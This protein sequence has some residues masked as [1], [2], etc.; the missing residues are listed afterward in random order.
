MKTALR[1]SAVKYL[2]TQPYI[3]GMEAELDRRWWKLELDTPSDCARKLADGQVDI[4]L[5]PV[6]AIPHL[7][8]YRPITNWGI[9]ADGAVKSV[10]LL[11]QVPIEEVKAVYFDYQSKTSNALLSILMKEFFH[12]EVMILESQEGYEE[13]IKSDVAGLV[14][15]DR[16]LTLGSRYPYCYDLAEAWKELTKLPFVFAR[17]VAGP[18]VTEEHQAVLERAFDMGMQMRG[19]IVRK[20]ESVYPNAD[21]D[22]YLHRDIKYELGLNYWRG[23]SLFEEKQQDLINSY[24]EKNI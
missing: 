19:E 9:G 1:I 8:G 13:G 16:A 18:H 6:A 22:A 4:G 3:F 2:N 10:L 21:I 11:S 17:W 24:T 15:G 5:V 7:E 14:I 20:V 12:Q 23:L